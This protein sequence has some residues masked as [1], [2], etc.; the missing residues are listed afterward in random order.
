MSDYIN[1][2]S[3]YWG[4]RNGDLIV[5]HQMTDDHLRNCV[6]ALMRKMFPVDRYYLLDHWR[7]FTEKSQM[8][9][10]LIH[11]MHRR[12]LHKHIPA[13]AQYLEVPKEYNYDRDLDIGDM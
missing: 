12:G 2:Q 4:M 9:F 3:I 8:S 5:P 6:F 11:E 13:L 10:L 1:G 7:E